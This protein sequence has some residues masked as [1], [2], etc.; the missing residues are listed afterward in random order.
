MPRARSR[1]CPMTP[2]SRTTAKGMPSH[3]CGCAP[4][5]RI[6]TAACSVRCKATHFG[7]GDVE[8][9][10][11]RLTGSA[12]SGP[13]RG[14]HQPPADRAD[15]V[16]P[17]ALRRRSADR[18]GSRNLPQRRAARLRQ[19]RFAASA[20][21]LTTFS[22]CTARTRSRSSLY[23][24][25]GQIRTREETDQRRPGQRARRQDLVLG[26]RST[27]PAATSSRWR[28]RRTARSAQG[29]GDRLARAWH[30]RHERRSAC[31][32]A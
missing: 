12:A 1:I 22:F 7:F 25:Q 13:R 23:G 9:F 4:T 5:A 2:R 30:R 17:H 20:M 27:S 21:C 10:D 16:R 19:V 24:P 32:R 14:H 15:G 11:S 8:G 28:S 18:L 6:P 26:R 3:A 31:S 29:A